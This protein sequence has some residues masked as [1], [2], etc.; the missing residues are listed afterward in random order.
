MCMTP[1]AASGR[2]K[3]SGSGKLCFLSQ[4]EA[5]TKRTKQAKETWWNTMPNLTLVPGFLSISFK[6]IL[7]AVKRQFEY[8][9]LH[10]I[11]KLNYNNKL[12]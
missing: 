2:I 5:I 12:W 10:T 9:L 6:T 7:L 11:F 3:S 8:E 4:Q 1:Q